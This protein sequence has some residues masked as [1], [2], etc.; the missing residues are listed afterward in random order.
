MAEHD[1]SGRLSTYRSVHGGVEAKGVD[2]RCAVSCLEWE[3]NWIWKRSRGAPRFDADGNIVC[4]YGSVEDT[5][6][7]DNASCFAEVEA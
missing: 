5:S 2:N 6:V 7:T 4:W 3:G 1:S